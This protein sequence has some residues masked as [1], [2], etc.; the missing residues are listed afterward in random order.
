MM[1]AREQA[2]YG[3]IATCIG[4]GEPPTLNSFKDYMLACAAM[5]GG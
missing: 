3:F 2:M 1:R 4:T 5:W